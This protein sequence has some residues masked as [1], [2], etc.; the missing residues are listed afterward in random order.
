MLRHGHDV[1]HAIFKQ[2]P[3]LLEKTLRMSV[4]GICAMPTGALEA[5]ERFGL[6]VSQ[7]GSADSA[8]MLR[9]S[10]NALTMALRIAKGL[11]LQDIPCVWGVYELV[12]VFVCVCVFVYSSAFS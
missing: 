12:L 11:G 2:R 5:V 7:S 10:R 8:S 1:V 3:L 6:L 4:H 9:N